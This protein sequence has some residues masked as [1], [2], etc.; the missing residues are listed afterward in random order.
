M[1]PAA[2]DALSPPR[3]SVVIDSAYQRPE[4]FGKI[5]GAFGSAAASGDFEEAARVLRTIR[6]GDRQRVDDNAAHFSDPHA[7][8]VVRAQPGDGL[9]A[10]ARRYGLL[11]VEHDETDTIKRLNPHIDFSKKGAGGVTA[12]QFVRIAPASHSPISV[13]RLKNKT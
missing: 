4:G 7:P 9:E 1:G 3:Q 12:G 8:G 13:R 6:G 10:I 2:F 11:T 5:A